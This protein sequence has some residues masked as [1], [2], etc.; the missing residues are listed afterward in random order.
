MM[1]CA[2]GVAFAPALDRLFHLSHQHQPPLQLP[3]GQLRVQREVCSQLDTCTSVVARFCK[4]SS[5]GVYPHATMRNC[6]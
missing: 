1:V 3:G 2:C 5:V 6:P 4:Y